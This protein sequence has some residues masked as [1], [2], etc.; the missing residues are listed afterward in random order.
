[1][2]GIRAEAEAI[3]TAEQKAQIEQRKLER[4]SRLEE[5]K[6]RREQRLKERQERTN[7]SPTI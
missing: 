5:R 7:K 1:M 6:L 2:E 3:L 4:K